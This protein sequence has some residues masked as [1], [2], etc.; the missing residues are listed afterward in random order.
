[1]LNCPC[2]CQ[3][4]PHKEQNAGVKTTAVKHGVQWGGEKREEERG[5]GGS[6]I[7]AKW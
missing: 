1:M 2:L 7:P 6:P 3:H 5:K 4:D